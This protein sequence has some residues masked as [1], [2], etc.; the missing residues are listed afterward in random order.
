MCVR[1]LEHDHSVMFFYAV[2][3]KLFGLQTPKTLLRATVAQAPAGVLAK[4]SI[5]SF[6]WGG[7]FSGPGLDNF[8][9]YTT[10]RRYTIMLRYIVSALVIVGVLVGGIMFLGAVAQS[11]EEL[12]CDELLCSAFATTGTTRAWW[13]VSMTRTASS[14]IAVREMKGGRLR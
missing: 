13:P 2:F 10:Q 12:S 9:H 6:F 11:Q 7:L 5:S 4:R 1:G 14:S 3:R 8:F